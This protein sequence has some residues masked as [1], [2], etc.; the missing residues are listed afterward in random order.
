MTAT[1]SGRR[2]HLIEELKQI[3]DVVGLDDLTIAELAA[4]TALLRPAYA[5]VDTGY[6]VP[7]RRDELVYRVKQ[8]MTVVP[9]EDLALEELRV[10]AAIVE[11]VDRGPVDLVG[12]L[13]D[14]D[15][16]RLA[17]RRRLNA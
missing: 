17:P 13:I 8:A 3:T 15:S 2:E 4:L 16:R 11:P 12:N 14:F 10:I 9:P 5:R 7:A 6:G 1:R